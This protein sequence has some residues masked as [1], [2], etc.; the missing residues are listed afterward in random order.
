MNPSA[1]EGCIPHAHFVERLASANPGARRA[2]CIDTLMLNVGLRCNLE[3][4]HCHQSSSPLRTES[5]TR[6]TMLEALQLAAMLHPG[7]LDITGGE[8]TLWPHLRELISAATAHD[9]PV[10]VRTN[11]VA[12]ADPAR[13][14]L[15]PFFAENDVA[16][17]ASLPGVSARAVAEQRGGIFD[18][19]ISVLRALAALGYGS[20]DPRL[21]LDLAYNPPLG[22]SPRPQALLAEEF[23]LA[24]E[25]LGV[26]FD[27]LLVIANVPAGRFAERLLSSGD[28][29]AELDRLAGAFNPD[30]LGEL[31]C[32]CGVEVAWD[33][34]LV[35]C[36][37]NLGAGLRV[38]DGPRTL[39]EALALADAG[40]DV[41][42]AIAGRRIAFGPHCFACAAGSGSG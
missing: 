20:G 3:C 14:A 10:R 31:A 13:A 12:L 24:L 2:V 6:E 34:S 33:G 30:V 29:S 27:E 41:L 25:P 4:V 21:V 37:F 19:T 1:T 5:M 23:R 28:Y 35:D 7:R 42:H 40:A 22:T 26:R 39:A 32:R 15:A 38:V 36:D 17:L 11:L 18:E 16:I 8:P 9:I